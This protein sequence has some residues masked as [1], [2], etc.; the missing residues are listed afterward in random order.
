MVGLDGENQDIGG[1]G[2]VRIGFR[3]RRADFIGEMFSRGGNR[4]SGDDFLGTDEFRLDETAGQ[5]GGHFARAEKADG[6]FGCHEN[7]VTGRLMERK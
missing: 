3:G 1:F 2:H 6:E 4:I 5:R 7:F